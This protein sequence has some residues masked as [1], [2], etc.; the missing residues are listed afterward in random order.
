MLFRSD[1]IYLDNPP[2]STL[3]QWTFSQLVMG[4]FGPRAAKEGVPAEPFGEEM[5]VMMNTVVWFLEKLAMRGE[6]TW[7]NKDVPIEEH[8][9]IF[10]EMMMGYFDRLISAQDN[11]KPA[12]SE[13]A[14][15]PLV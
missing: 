6:L 14:A 15:H 1:K 4:G 9:R 2:V 8:L 5:I 3:T 10:E 11:P 7:A 12:G 13:P